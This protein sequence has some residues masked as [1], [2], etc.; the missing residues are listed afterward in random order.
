MLKK[1]LLFVTCLGAYAAAEADGGYVVSYT[2]ANSS[3]N[4]ATI[5]QSET[6]SSTLQEVIQ[7]VGTKT[8]TG[9]LKKVK[10]V[11]EISDVTALSAITC[12]TIDL[13][14]AVLPSVSTGAFTNVNVK[15]VVLP[16]GMAKADVNT[17]A[18]SRFTNLE[19][20]A[21]VDFVTEMQGKWVYDDDVIYEGDR[22]DESGTTAK[23]KIS[24]DVPLTVKSS[25]YTYN[26]GEYKGT[27]LVDDSNKPY[28]V[29]SEANVVSL[30]EHTGYIYSQYGARSEYTG[31]TSV[32][33]DGTI[34][35]CINP[36]STHTLTLNQTISY[37]Y[38]N[39]QYAYTGRVYDNGYG[40]KRFYVGGTEVIIS[41]AENPY[42]YEKDG[43]KYIY[44]GPIASNDWGGKIGH[45]GGT[46][47]T[48]TA[49]TG[50]YMNSSI[51]TGPVAT[52]DD[53]KK[54]G[55]SKSMEDAKE[56]TLVPE[57]SYVISENIDGLGYITHICDPETPYSSQYTGNGYYYEQGE[58]K[59]IYSGRV[60]YAQ[61]DT[62]QSKPLGFNNDY[63]Q[64]ELTTGTIYTYTNG[65]GE[66]VTY[67]G[68]VFGENIGYIDGEDI[69]LT[70]NST[71]VNYYE[72]DGK[73]IV[74]SGLVS[75]DNY[76]CVGYTSSVQLTTLSSPTE[77]NYYEE[78][79]K[80]VIYSGKVYGDNTAYVGGQEVTLTYETYYKNGESIYNGLRTADNTKGYTSNDAFELTA[81]FVYAYTDPDTGEE[82]TFS[83]TDVL[84]TKTVERTVE[85]TYKEVDVA[86]GKVALTAYVNTPGTLVYTLMNMSVFH[87]YTGGGWQP[88]ASSQH[89]WYITDTGGYLYKADNV[90]DLTLSG[91]LNA[92]DMN[93]GVTCI[94]KTTMHYAT[95][96]EL[97]Q[98]N[99]LLNCKP[100][101][102][103]LSDALFG[104]G[105]G[106]HPEDMTVSGF[107]SNTESIK[108]I[109]LPTA[110][111]QNTIPADFI[112]NCSGVT[113]LCIPYNYEIIGE[114]AF[115]N[116]SGLSH[117]YT[118][119]PRNTADEPDNVDVD[120]GDGSFT[121]SA[122]LKEIKSAGTQD[123]STFFGNAMQNNVRDVYNLAVKA[124][125]CGA[126]A[127]QGDLTFG[128]NGFKGNWAH[129]ICRENYKGSSNVICILHYPTES[130]T[131]TREG[132]TCVEAANYEDLTRV[133]T[134]AD[135][136]GAVDG[137]GNTR[138][139][140]RHAE[141]YRSFNQAVSGHIW[142]AWKLYIDETADYKEVVSEYSE[143]VV[144]D[145]NKTY[146]QADYQGWH[147]FVLTENN[148]F[149]P[150]NP[151]TTYDEFVEKDWY[152][153]CV[154]YDIKKS[155]LLMA[156]GVKADSN[157]KV[158][159]LKKNADG[160]TGTELEADFSTVT[161]DI[162]PDVRTLVQV[163][164]S[165][166]ERKVTL[167]LSDKLVTAE[168]C[169]DVTI[170]DDRQGYT[171][172]ELTGSDPVVMKGGYPYLIRPL[173]P[174]DE[175]IKN[176][177]AYVVAVAEQN[178][179]ERS[180]YTGGIG[181]TK[182]AAAGTTFSLPI[183]EGVETQA[184][185]KDKSDE[186]TKVY[187]TLDD[188]EGSPCMYNFVGTYLNGN[189][190]QYGYY[191]GVSKTTGKHQFF[192]TTKTTTKWNPYSAIIKG[193][194]TPEFTV[195]D[196][197]ES[198]TIENIRRT[199]S[200]DQADDLIILA[201]ESQELK[202]KAMTLIMD[203]SGE[204]DGITTAIRD[205]D[206]DRNMDKDNKVYTIGGVLT[207][208]GGNLQ[209]GIYVKNGKKLVV[210]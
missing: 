110:E 116:A 4:V 12:P 173:L 27:V 19:S 21:S 26:G 101:K 39:G 197:S 178:G 147:E 174:D 166:N 97:V 54:Y 171:Y 203:D 72:E 181:E 57:G 162:Y 5:T 196:G 130:K 7:A 206:A 42:T 164:R 28:G 52:D 15:Y 132:G 90:R 86:T 65:E 193:F 190:P 20:A 167:C 188:S 71:A 141:F 118:T 94:D 17:W 180:T 3:E 140:P 186:T 105:E 62:E 87:N 22:T 50:Y 112:N 11:G 33:E 139:W 189:V 78:D 96:G 60:F 29:T 169:L 150:F 155:E 37:T 200:P 114:R 49:S 1:L 106:Y 36:T 160:T 144:V 208:G 95:T 134:L 10:I 98:W 127:F 145:A 146:N 195:P 53:G 111:S 8:F 73:K 183:K 24:V 115:Y 154:P 51:Y 138:A 16:N 59:I 129:P 192:R 55:T 58:Y 84:T 66:T 137:S 107:Y 61:D 117:I 143:G 99:A 9:G 198:K 77:V 80:L 13:S 82:V 157:N 113:S 46:E 122:N 89:G 32:Q 41:A 83:S 56:L 23:G 202:G 142:D 207:N 75:D 158:R 191:L 69:N 40:Q 14:E 149:I 185:N 45:I 151:Q 172:T 6:G 81:S 88:W 210:K 109:I 168:K 25:S 100:E 177:G 91:N 161:E 79:G 128:N 67:K 209:K 124:P 38:D 18:K 153:I 43:V 204:D 123:K 152:T 126:Y 187:V 103:D 179:F 31:L 93:T 47:V 92:V 121:F 74:Y 170:P 148:I 175:R 165:V 201:S 108:E 2:D 133:Y 131:Y 120:H 119:D 48:L 182:D 34:Y 156:L 76:G 68:T 85:L 30:T 199:F 194:T 136:T 163:K 104:E 125:K 63:T 135:E 102:I 64:A 176:I 205:I 184:L 44:D 159:R 70:A 35:G